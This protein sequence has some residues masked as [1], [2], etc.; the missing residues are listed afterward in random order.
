MSD[1]FGP[2]RFKV[3]LNEL[4]RRGIDGPALTGALSS[5]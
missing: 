5:A 3:Y 2:G 1:Q 4:T